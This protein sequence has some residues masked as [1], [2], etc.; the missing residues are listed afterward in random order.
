MKLTPLHIPATGPEARSG[1]IYLLALLAYPEE[2]ALAQRDRFVFALSSWLT[3]KHGRIGRSGLM[4]ELLKYPDQQMDNQIN[5]C[6]RRIEKRLV[7]ARLATR[8]LVRMVRCSSPDPSG[9][10]MVDKLVSGDA[11]ISQF[12][13]IFGQGAED[14]AGHTP[15][16]TITSVIRDH[17]ASIVRLRPRH[18]DARSSDDPN[19]TIETEYGNVFTRI[20]KP[21][22]PVLHLAIAFEFEARELFLADEEHWHPLH[23]L[24]E[25]SWLPR[26]L[27]HAESART[28]YIPNS[29]LGIAAAEMIQVLPEVA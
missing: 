21:A 10:V 13:L 1:V 7:A 24:G 28:F 19:F 3:K 2:E 27:K 8:V 18:K 25:P 17:A 6:W 15:S 12:Y 16:P 29:T 5:S 26:C 14:A 9:L 20:W 23:T 22:K 4:R 11:E